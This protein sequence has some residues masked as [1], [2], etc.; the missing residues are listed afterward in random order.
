MLSDYQVSTAPDAPDV[1]LLNPP[2]APN[3]YFVEFGW[4]PAEPGV[5]VPGPDTVWQAEGGELRPDNP[6]TLRWDNGEGL[7]FVREL[8]IDDDY[9]LTVTQRVEPRGR[10]GRRTACGR[11]SGRGTGR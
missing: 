4:V 3:P 9:M 11:R 8:A 2:G 10:R 7:R 6:V 5:A 1:T